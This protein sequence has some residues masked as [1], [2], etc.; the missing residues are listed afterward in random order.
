MTREEMLLRPMAYMAPE[1]ILDGLTADDA[2]RRVP[3]ISHSI[4]EILAHLAFWQTWFLDR[5]D[6]V[7]SPLPEHAAGGWPDATSADWVRLRGS[8]LNGLRRAVD[9][10]AQGPVSPPIDL[11]QMAHFTVEDLIHE[12]ASHSAHHLGQIIT[13][14]Q[15]LGLWPPPGGSYTW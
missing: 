15:A 8:F 11:P 10:T 2:A 14:R 1:Q 6:G 4:V 13:L 5:C 3:G 12:M 7:A 9:I